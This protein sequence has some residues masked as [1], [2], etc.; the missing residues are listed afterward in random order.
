[1]PLLHGEDLD[2]LIGRVGALH[3]TVAVRLVLQA[4]HGVMAAH[5]AGVIHRDIKPQNIFL[6]Q[7]SG[8]VTAKVC[9]FGLA[10]AEQHAALTA[11]G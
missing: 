8:V 4:A 5:A 10:K 2:G 11:T 6:D 9:D 1:M 3:P 7:Q